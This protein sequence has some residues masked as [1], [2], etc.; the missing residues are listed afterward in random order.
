MWNFLLA[1]F[2]AQAVGR[3]RVIRLILLTFFLGALIASVIYTAVVF[4]AVM[5]RSNSD[6]VHAHHSR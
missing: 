6:H 3:S 5:Q 2:S 1:F 4:E